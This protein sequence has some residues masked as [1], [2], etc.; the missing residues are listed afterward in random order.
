MWHLSDDAFT[1]G[2]VKVFSIMGFTKDCSDTFS[3]R[4]RLADE[5][6]GFIKAVKAFVN[7][8][9]SVSESCACFN[10]FVVVPQIVFCAQLLFLCSRLGD[11]SLK[12]KDEAVSLEE[13]RSDFCEVTS[14]SFAL[15]YLGDFVKDFYRSVGCGNK[16]RDGGRCD[17]HVSSCVGGG[18]KGESFNPTTRD[19]NAICC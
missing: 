5:M 19:G 13:L 4:A 7:R 15:D 11:L 3:V 2:A 10:Q 9:Q 12:L 6:V 14:D 8:S 1:S 17:D 16:C 18:C